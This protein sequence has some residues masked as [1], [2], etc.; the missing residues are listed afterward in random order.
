MMCADLEVQIGIWR[1]YAML[2]V[3]SAPIPVEADTLWHTGKTISIVPSRSVMSN[4]IDSTRWW[5][6]HVSEAQWSSPRREI[7]RLGEHKAI[8]SSIQPHLDSWARRARTLTM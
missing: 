3:H 6:T 1:L 8:G 5:P 7:I 2:M 4:E